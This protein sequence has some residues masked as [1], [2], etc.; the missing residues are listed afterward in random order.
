MPPSPVS[1]FLLPHPGR[2][3]EQR[4][5]LQRGHLQDVASRPAL[6]PR[7]P[8]RNVLLF[9]DAHGVSVVSLILT[10]AR[11]EGPELCCAL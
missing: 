9:C 10:P 7:L 3:G 4:W 8:A 11:L 1:C 6:R 2:L 5:G